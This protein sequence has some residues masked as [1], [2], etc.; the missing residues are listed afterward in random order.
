MKLKVTV[1]GRKDIWIPNRES[2][3]QFIKSK[4]FEMIH[5]F[6]P[7]RGMIIGADHDVASVLTDVDNG[8][9]FAVFTDPLANMGHSLAI[10]KNEKLECYNI[11]KISKDDL[12]ILK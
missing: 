7:T 12:E 4:D 1:E 2:L 11:G 8:D 6:I 3:K 10:I 9:R 5:N